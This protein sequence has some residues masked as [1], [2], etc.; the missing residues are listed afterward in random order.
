MK[1]LQ[2]IEFYKL[3]ELSAVSENVSNIFRSST[4]NKIGK[5]ER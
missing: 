2:V 1:N 5:S 3:L 4:K